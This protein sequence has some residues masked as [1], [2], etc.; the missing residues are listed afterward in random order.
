MVCERCQPPLP[1]RGLLLS[2]LLRL[3]RRV[4]K[5]YSR[6]YP[7]SQLRTYVHEPCS[8]VW[9]FRSKIIV[10]LHETR[11][12]L[13]N[14]SWPVTIAWLQN[15]AFLR[16]NAGAARGMIVPLDTWKWW[17]ATILVTGKPDRY[18]LWG[19]RIYIVENRATNV[20]LGEMFG[21][22]RAW[23]KWKTHEQRHFE[24]SLDDLKFVASSILMKRILPY[25]DNEMFLS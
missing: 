18:R 17:I 25:L 1:V 23:D 16:K 3:K 20:P 9:Y 24:E 11:D 10:A 19:W 4:V 14:F 2:N 5:R 15:F 12:W 22:Y 7:R 21:L 13:H 8:K 6:R